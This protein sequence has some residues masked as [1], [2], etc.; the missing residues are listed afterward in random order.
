[1]YFHTQWNVT[2]GQEQ[3][4][5]PMPLLLSIWSM[6]FLWSVQKRCNLQ[7]PNPIIKQGVKKS[8]DPNDLV[9]DNFGWFIA[10]FLLHLAR[11]N[12]KNLMISKIPERLHS[13][14]WCLL[15]H[16]CI[17]KRSTPSLRSRV[18]DRCLLGSKSVLFLFSVII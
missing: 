3:C 10:V 4:L 5:L 11:S 1:M 18:R 6:V 12:K 8:K 13:L 15:L 9:K 16:T 2:Y 7:V 17:W 14:V